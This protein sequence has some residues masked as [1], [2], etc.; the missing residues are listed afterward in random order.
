MSKDDNKKNKKNVDAAV[1][2]AAMKALKD[3]TVLREAWIAA[4][5]AGA[6]AAI[7]VIRKASDAELVELAAV[8]EAKPGKKE[9]KKTK[10]PEKTPLAPAPVPSAT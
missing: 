6:A 1:R 9:N 7:N 3:A 4:I 8:T 2:K 10:E 5:E